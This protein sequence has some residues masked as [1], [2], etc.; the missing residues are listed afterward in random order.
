MLPALHFSLRSERAH[1]VSPPQVS[2]QRS[3]RRSAS[4]R[5]PVAAQGLLH[6]HLVQ[7]ERLPGALLSRISVVHLHAQGPGA[8]SSCVQHHGRHLLLCHLHA[9]CPQQAD[10]RGEGPGNLALLHIV[11]SDPGC[12]CLVSH[13][14]LMSGTSGSYSA[15]TTV[16]G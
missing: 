12:R 3:G 15:K 6:H 1:C 11:I 2:C 14:A 16:R 9:A 10:L 8:R 7:R 5:T 4:G 13:P